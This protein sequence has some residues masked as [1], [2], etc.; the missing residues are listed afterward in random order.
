[1][2]FKQLPPG[3]VLMLY[4]ALAIIIGAGL[5]CL[6]AASNGT[7]LSFLDA[8]FTATSAQCVT[9]LAVVDTGTQ[10]TLFGQWVILSLIQIGGLGITTFSV[11]LFIYLRIG[12]SVR[13]RW[14]INETLL[15]TPIGSWR[16]LLRDIFLMTFVI[17]GI[18]TLLLSCAFI[19]EQG[20]LPGLYSAL[21][22]SVS[23]FCNAGFSLFSNSMVNFQG[24]A[25]VNLTLIM[26]I[27]CGGIGF[28]VIRELV[29][30]GY[31]WR[32]N[33]KRLRISLHSKIVL[34]T[35][36]ILTVFGT[37][38]IWVME[39]RGSLAGHSFGDGL[40]IALFQSVSS[41]TA[42]FNS[43]DL[44]QFHVATI[45]LMILLM[46]VGASPG[47]C[48]GGIKTTSLA[49]FFAV[50]CNRLKGSG[51]TSLFRRT[52]PDEAI[53]KALTLTIMAL[54]LI[55]IALFSLLV[56]QTGSLVNESKGMFLDYL[57][58]TFSAFATVG[59]TI[60]ATA[61]LTVAGKLIVILLMFIGR[62]GLLTM[63]F[64]IAGRARKDGGRYAEENIMIG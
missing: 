5:L 45:F 43:I 39:F 57:F 6:P 24:S 46:F 32:K 8:L 41:R 12:V 26:L 4:Y 38:A 35:S 25:L 23:A 63:A 21:F 40:W 50:F 19:P 1:M 37:L 54:I 61:Q 56:A 47:S 11:Y 51:H 22:H 49:L 20:F 48:G 30:V 17:E 29:Q 62:V 7:P 36:L 64:A 58:E 33:K 44:N 42:G 27:S 52:I 14:I 9:G 59:L 15:Q 3:G 2:K 10:F 13:G 28:L 18:G 34:T 55:G 60:G 53:S 16:E 31:A